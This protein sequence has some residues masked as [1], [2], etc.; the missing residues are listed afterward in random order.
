MKDIKNAMV[1]ALQTVDTNHASHDQIIQ[2]Q[3][4][5]LQRLTAK[6]DSLTTAMQAH[7]HC[8]GDTEIAKI[9]K[10]GTH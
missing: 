8:G 5:Y 2:A 1:H 9:N 3:A 10:M 6:Q 7:G 4:Q